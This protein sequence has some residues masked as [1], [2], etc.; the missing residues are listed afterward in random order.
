MYSVECMSCVRSYVVSMKVWLV[1]LFN[2]QS[3]LS[4]KP[5][6]I[7]KFNILLNGNHWTV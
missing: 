1:S 4:R 6:I 2:W 3:I 5:N 7:V